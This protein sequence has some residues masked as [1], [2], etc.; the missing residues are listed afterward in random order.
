MKRSVIIVAGGSGQR[1]GAQMP[2]QFLLL[3]GMPVLMHAIRQFHCFDP[4]MPLVVALPP[5][6]ISTWTQ[7]CAEHRFTIPHTVTAG[8][9]TRFDSV[10][11]ALH[12]L[13]GTDWIAVHDGVRPLVSPA[14]I[15]RCFETALK[16]GAAVPVIP[17]S[18]SLRMLEAGGNHSVLRENYCIVQTPQIFRARWLKNAYRAPCCP[19]FTDDA[20]VVEAA[21]YK[22]ALAE[23]SR[24]NIKITEPVDLK[25]AELLVPGF[26]S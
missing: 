4:G 24:E 7:L 9:G 13:P 18:N 2:K 17:L 25:I 11:K 14:L 6:H 3:A 12:A 22:I 10:K 23:G 1:M 20:S 8:G 15:A 26:C 5:A 21:G 19:S 16:H